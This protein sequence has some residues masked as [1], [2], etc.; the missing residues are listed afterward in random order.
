M[1]TRACIRQTVMRRPRLPRVS[2][3]ST[4]RLGLGLGLG[5]RWPASTCLAGLPQ[6]CLLAVHPQLSQLFRCCRLLWKGLMASIKVP[7]SALVYMA[8]GWWVV[9]GH[10]RRLP[11]RG[12]VSC[13]TR[14]PF[15]ATA[16]RRMQPPYTHTQTYAGA[17][18]RMMIIYRE[19]GGEGGLI[20]G[21]GTRS[22]TSS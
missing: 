17:I 22:L 12:S 10:S 7:P 20:W 16:V 14:L 9:P 18:V 21:I 1:A 8:C 15:Q 2:F 5:L 6:G 3:A 11:V 13:T 19:G 4:F